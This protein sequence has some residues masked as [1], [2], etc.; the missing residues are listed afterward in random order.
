MITSPNA[1]F[2]VLQL[3]LVL[4][5]FGLDF[6]HGFSLGES[7][8][9]F[10]P[11]YRIRQSLAVAISRMH[12]PPLGGYLAYQSVIDALDE[13]GFAVF[14]SDNGP[15]LDENGWTALFND[16]ARLN[17]ALQQAKDTFIDAHLPPQLI[18]GNELAYA[19]YMYGAFS[20]FGLHFSSLYY[21]Y[22]LLLGVACLLFV[23]E[24]WR[25]PFLIFLLTTYL[26]GLFF[27]QNY[28][29]IQGP[30]LASL[31]NSRLF[32]AL[33]L[34]PATHILL[35]TWKRLPPRVVTFTTVV[36]QSVLL[37]FLLDCRTVGLWQI[38]MVAVMGVA[39]TAAAAWTRR[40]SGTSWLKLS[41]AGWPAAVAVITLAMQIGL[42]KY[43]A[44]PRYAAETESHVIW[45]EVLSG[46]LGSSLQ[47]Q[48][49]YLAKEAGLGYYP[50]QLGYDAVIKDLN[51]RNDKSSPIVVT[52]NDRICIDTQ[53]GYAAYERLERSLVLR[54]VIEHPLAVLGGII[55]KYREQAPRFARFGSMAWANISG[56]FI[57]AALGGLLWIAAGRAGV[58]NAELRS[59]IAFA[60]IVM[61]FA[62]APIAI[63]TSTLWVGTLMVFMIAAVVGSFATVAVAVK[64]ITKVVASSAA[65]A[66]SA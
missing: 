52:C 30:Q 33:S 57:I 51:D 58:S 17:R 46:V 6:G 45:H 28:A 66:P 22:F 38:A 49:V 29:Q 60:L 19:D 20:L 55:E 16:P 41:L 7:D 5:S 53:R 61:L 2:R 4:A 31:A 15:H 47:L 27:L 18:Q 44:D 3:V 43:K 54:I 40:R 56:A 35:A 23:V 64:A 42:I 1:V 11:V 32:D 13:N 26:A 59:S 8:I 9:G 37:A 39:F 48:S 10:H 63:I 62:A 65:A 24:F 34:L 25:S 14:V 12:Q 36:A 50:D 21:F